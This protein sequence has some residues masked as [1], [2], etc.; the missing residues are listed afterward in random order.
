MVVE[1]KHFDSLTKQDLDIQENIQNSLAEYLFP[2]TEF[3]IGSIYEEI[4]IPEDL[5]KY[6]DKTL[7]FA[8]GERMYFGNEEVRSL[9]YPNLSDGASYGSL[10]FTPCQSFQELNARVLIVDHETGVNGGIM[11][12]D[13][14]KELVSDCYGKVSLEMAEQLTGVKKTPFQFRLGIKPQAES[15]VHRIAKG[16]LAPANLDNLSGGRVSTQH[17][18]QGKLIAKTG[19]DLI[20]PTSSFKGRKEG[21]E[22]IKPGEYNLKVGIGIKTLAKYGE[23]SLGTQVLVNYPKAVQAEILPELQKEAKK[24]AANQSSPQQLA[25][26]Y[27]ELYERRKEL[28][29]GEEITEEN[30]AQLEG[31]DE[32]IDEAFGDEVETQNRA[33]QDWALYRILKAD[34][35]GKLT[36]HPKIIAELNNF[37]RKRWVDIAT[38]RAIKFKAGLAQPSLRLKEDEICIPIIPH[39][40]EVIVTRSPLINSNGVIVLKNRHLPEVTHLQGAVHIHPDTAAKFLQCDYDGDRLA[41]EA[42]EKYPVLAAEVK[43]YNL[44]QN[45]YPDIVKRDKVAYQGTFPE[46][47]L[48]AADNKIGLIANQ[49]QRAVALRW[50]TYALPESNKVGYV[51]NIAQKM[52]SLVA[53][54]KKAGEEWRKKIDSPVPKS[55]SIPDKYKERVDSL[56][57][58]SD[59][60]SPEAVSVKQ[61]SPEEID[62]ALETVRSINFDLVADLGNE[63]QVAV[64]GPKS[65]ARPDE[66]QLKNLKAVGGYKYPKWLSDKKNSQAY[67]DRP[68]N[69]NGYSPIDLMVQQTNKS[70]QENKLQEQTKEN[71]NTLSA[72]VIQKDG[73]ERPIGVI[74]AEEIKE[75]G[76][77]PGHTLRG[78]EISLE[79]GITKT[80]VQAMF[81]QS[82][83]YLE[84]FR[85][86]IPEQEKEAL[87][88]ALWWVSH[89]KNGTAYRKSSVA[90]NLFPEQIV[91]QLEKPPVQ[92]LTISGVLHSP[93]YKGKIWQGEK[94]NCEIIE[95]KERGSPNFGKKVVWV[96]GKPL[97]SFVRD[98]ASLPDRTKFSAAITSPPGAAVIATTPKGNKI[99]VTQIKNFAYPDIDCQ[100]ESGNLKLDYS[101][102]KGK[103]EPVAIL[104]NKILG[105]IH[106]DNVKELETEDRQLISEKYKVVVS[107]VRPPSP[108]A[109]LKVDVDSLEYSW[110]SQEKES[111][112]VSLEDKSLKHNSISTSKQVKTL[113]SEAKSISSEAAR[114]VAPI[115]KDFLKLKE[116]E[117][118]QGQKYNAAW[119]ESNQ[120][121]TLHDSKGLTK[122]EAQYINGEWQS[123]VDNLT[124]EDV[125][126]FQ[127]MNPQIQEQLQENLTIEQKRQVLRQE[128]ESLKG[129]IQAKPDFHN[130]G[131]EKKDI[132]IAMLVID[133]EAKNPTGKNLLNLVGGILSQSDQLR[134]WKG[135]MPEAEYRGKAKDYIV[136]KFEQASQI[137]ESILADRQQSFDLAR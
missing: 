30:Y 94:A 82:Q 64:D 126:V 90:L 120:T 34:K 41:F 25:Q 32:V 129:E 72:V 79:P 104:N 131:V 130:A 81:K 43:E 114:I 28:I 26:E 49:I 109:H 137:R 65:A 84:Q 73:V 67:L 66:K 44:E 55:I 136:E 121:L 27:I 101:F 7:Q 132:A 11:P 31:F 78:A 61:L 13:I 105:I 24:L 40:K 51:K 1:I 29:Q 6:Q 23:Q 18:E 21:Y 22:P 107:L 117:D 56:A 87:A 38:G 98:S 86:G 100:G 80:Q 134:E 52:D 93:D 85:Q 15:P 58:L 3:A 71:R 10:V 46:I 99:K 75:H 89:G 119:K 103:R 48:L 91:K 122:L 37:A 54:S 50:E 128:Y 123:Q 110:Q 95:D 113:P 88:A 53:E 5:E 106:K 127:R 63:L 112:G 115:V 125:K 9:V 96:E 47:A 102:H 39:G 77:K 69:T 42:A 2:D 97:G 57:S 74:S 108:V 92:D 68:M 70:F 35:H 45:R 8:S 33:E 135:S 60:P 116:T 124:A 76:L 17:S 83:D 62:R 4:S 12:P 118:Y 111:R 16:T 19:Y 36:E 59:P 133:K 14:A 20:I